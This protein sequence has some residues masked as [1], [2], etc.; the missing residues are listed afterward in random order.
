MT[1]A[2]NLC[3][4][5]MR[6]RTLLLAHEPEPDASSTSLLRVD[7]ID[8]LRRLPSRQRQ[9]TILHYIG[10][11]SIRQVSEWMNISDGSVKSHLSKARRTLR[12]QLEVK[13]DPYMKETRDAGRQ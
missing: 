13:D 5:Q 9:A 7:L 4:R 6:Q 3:R 12:G 8:A 1:T 2:L 10:D 11:Y